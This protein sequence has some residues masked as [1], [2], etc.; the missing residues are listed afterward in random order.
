MDLTTVSQFVCELSVVKRIQKSSE[1]KRQVLSKIRSSN[2]PLA[3]EFFCQTES[4]TVD[5]GVVGTLSLW[6]QS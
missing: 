5:R 4:S 1:S 3:S 6:S 2:S